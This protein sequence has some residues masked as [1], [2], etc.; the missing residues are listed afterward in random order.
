MKLSFDILE[1]ENL[2]EM[3]ENRFFQ[4]SL[5]QFEESW[6]DNPMGEEMMNMYIKFCQKKTT[7]PLQFMKIISCVLK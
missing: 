1:L 2:Y 4:S 6:R 3:E 5:S 7:L